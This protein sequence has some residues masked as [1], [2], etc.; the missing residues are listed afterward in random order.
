MGGGPSHPRRKTFG[1]GPRFSGG[2][3]WEA[4]VPVLA[5]AAGWTLAALHLSARWPAVGA[6]AAHNSSL[7]RINCM[8]NLSLAVQTGEGEDGPPQLTTPALL[9]TYLA[10]VHRFAVMVSPG[11]TEPEDLA[12]QAM[13]KAI[14]H[15]DRFD[16]RRG[17]LDAWLW[18]IVVNVA[19]DAGRAARRRDY[20]LERVVGRHRDAFPQASPEDIVLS[21]L[22]DAA[23]VDAVRRLPRRYR[24]VIALRYG[25]CLSSQ[26]VADLIHTTRMAVAKTTRRAL[27]MLR[28]DLVTSEKYQ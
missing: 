18:G 4:M 20:L 5:I 10:R 27:D 24:T 9:A 23:L 22:R 14:E 8:E 11:G 21:K 3:L 12:Q 2:E 17:S 25:A 1:R 19:Q 7:E 28:R 15:A 6:H 26:D 16:A 13:L